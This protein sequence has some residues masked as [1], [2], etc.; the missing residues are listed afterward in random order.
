MARSKLVGSGPVALKP[1]TR[2]ALK[3]A[4]TRNA[5]DKARAPSQSAGKNAATLVQPR[6]DRGYVMVKL[7]NVTVQAKTLGIAAGR[8]ALPK[9]IQESMGLQDAFLVRNVK[10]PS[11]PEVLVINPAALDKELRQV[12][13]SRTL[14]AIVDALPFERRGVPRLRLRPLPDAGIQNR[15]RVPILGAGASSSRKGVGVV[16]VGAAEEG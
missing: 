11:A 5:T 8:I 2:S 14:G 13:P 4:L 6:L 3:V 1:A 16:N 9:M 7:G 12:R 10:N 15:L